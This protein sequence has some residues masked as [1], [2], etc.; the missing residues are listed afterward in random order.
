M[1]IILSRQCIN[2]QVLT[3]RQINGNNWL[4]ITVGDAQYKV[5][6]VGVRVAK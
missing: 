4:V 6:T 2:K 3:M 5:Y 1:K